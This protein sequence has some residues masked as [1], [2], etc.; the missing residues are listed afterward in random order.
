MQIIRL[1]KVEE[2]AVVQIPNQTNGVSHEEK[3]ILP[4]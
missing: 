4:L 3:K 2:I 1:N